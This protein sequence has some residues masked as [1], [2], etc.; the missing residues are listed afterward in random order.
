MGELDNNS[1]VRNP[2]WNAPFLYLRVAGLYGRIILECILIQRLR[3]WAE[4]IWLRIGSEDGFSIDPSGY[5]ESK[6]FPDYVR[7]YQILTIALF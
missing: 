3:I 6:K 2:G 5:M 7:D 4:F 1:E